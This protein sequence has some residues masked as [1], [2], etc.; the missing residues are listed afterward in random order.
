[1]TGDRN[2]T[3]QLY[4]IDGNGRKAIAS[5]DGGIGLHRYTL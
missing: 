2:T 1:M 4:S 5:T 3:S